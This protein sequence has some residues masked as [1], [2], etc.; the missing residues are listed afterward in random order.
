MVFKLA[1]EAERTRR[2]LNDYE[3][4]AKVLRG[5]R[6]EDGLEILQAA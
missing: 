5:V 2:K 4:I 1:R 6:F 3:L